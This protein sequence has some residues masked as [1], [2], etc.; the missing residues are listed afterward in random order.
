[1]VAIEVM[2]PA[3]PRSSS[4]ARC[5]ASSI[6]SGER[7]ASGCSREAGVVIDGVPS[8]AIIGCGDRAGACSASDAAISRAAASV[9]MVRCASAGSLGRIVGAVMR[10]A[11]FAARPGGRRDQERRGRHVAQRD[12]AGFALDGR[13]RRAPLPRA[14]RHRGSRR[15]ARSSARA[16]L[17]PASGGM[18]RIALV[19]RR[20]RQAGRR[21]DAV[22]LDVL[23]DARGIDHGFEQRVRGE[24]VGAMRAGRGDFAAG[25]QALRARCG[26]ARPR[27]CRPCGNARRARPGSAACA[28]SMP[29]AMQLA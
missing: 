18:A 5:T 25:P 9:V 11:A 20:G 3:R 26:R 22:A 1:M 2:S 21:R 10:A 13:E 6:A 24:P 23:G 7:K 14:A 29:A 19:C 28:G 15:H 12:I 16:G 4:S 27:R 17:L 8:Q